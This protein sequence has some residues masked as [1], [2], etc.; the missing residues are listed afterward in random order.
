M[1][2]R[3]RSSES[4]FVQPVCVVC[5]LVT[6]C[7]QHFDFLSS[8]TQLKKTNQTRKGTLNTFKI[9]RHF[10]CTTNLDIYTIDRKVE[11]F[12]QDAACQGDG[13]VTFRTLAVVTQPD[14]RVR[15]HA[16]ILPTYLRV[17]QGL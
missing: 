12:E 14:V 16:A 11:I 2:R 3:L 6:V 7:P 10:H 4:S 5:P 1:R 9:Q 13:M 15:V 17:L 8:V